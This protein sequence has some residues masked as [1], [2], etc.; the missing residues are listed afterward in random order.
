MGFF[1]ALCKYSAVLVLLLAILIGSLFNDNTNVLK[2]VGLFIYLDGVQMARGTQLR[3]IAPVV[4]ESIPWG[5]TE[6]GI[7]DLT[8]QTVLITGGNSGLGYWTAFHVAKHKGNA[9]ITCRTQKRC[10]EA[11]SK[12]MEATGREVRTGV[13]D[14]SSFASIRSFAAT[15]LKQ[16]KDLHSLV[17]NAGVMMPPFSTTKEGLELQIGT[18]HFGHF[19]LTD[20]LLPLVERTASPKV[21]PTVVVVSSS[22]HYRSY[23]EG[24]RWTLD[25]M[26]DES[27]YVTNLAYGQSK[28]ANVLFAQELA[29]R[30]KEKGILVNSIHPGVVATELARHLL[31]RIQG[32]IGAS[33]TAFVKEKILLRVLWEPRDAA[34]TQLYTAI[35]PDLIARKVS[36]RY[37]HPIARENMPDPHAA[38]QTLQHRLWQLSADFISKH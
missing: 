16:Q 17:L 28:L 18:N 33:L 21:T 35:A 19:L 34:L 26:N 1:K 13:L 14:L 2:Q 3:G 24:I 29:R 27:T 32:F 11:A 37:F 25:E 9:V 23:P 8:N 12:L 6:N 36:G 22:A 5:F 15:F 7:P 4:H 38:N 31:V 10:D 20:L 30:V